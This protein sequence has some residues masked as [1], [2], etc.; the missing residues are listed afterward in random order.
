[1]SGRV[2]EDRFGSRV[3][4]QGSVLRWRHQGTTHVAI[5]MGRVDGQSHEWRTTA[6]SDSTTWEHIA[7]LIG[8]NPCAVA[9][10]WTEVPTLGVVDFG[11][12]ATGAYARELA[13]RAGPDDRP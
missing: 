13:A 9:S 1:M 12:D 11:D 7:S 3:P 10:G 6:R 4:P 2:R 5:H 8:N